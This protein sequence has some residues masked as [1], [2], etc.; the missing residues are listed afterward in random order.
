[1]EEEVKSVSE[2]VGEVEVC[3]KVTLPDDECPIPFSFNISLST[4][5]GTAGIYRH[6]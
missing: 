5:D 3:I 1:M 4:T 2:G 6:N